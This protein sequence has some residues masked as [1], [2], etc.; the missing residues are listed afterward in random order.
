MFGVQVPTTCPGVPDGQ[1][2]PADQWGGDKAAY[3]TKAKELAKAFV[4][5]FKK[6]THM[7]Q[8]VVDAGPKAE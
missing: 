7:P 4:E 5:N 6:Y 2:I 1:L 8:D 3:E